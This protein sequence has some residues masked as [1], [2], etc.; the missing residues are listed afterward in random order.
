MPMDVKLTPGTYVVAVSGGIDSMTLLHVLAQQPGLKLV[1]AHYDHGIRSDSKEDRRLVETLSQK[2]GLD[3]E[4]VEGNLDPWV[5]EAEARTKRYEF[6]RQISKKHHAKGIITA[7]HYDDAVETLA[8]NVIRGTKRKGMTAMRSTEEIIRPLLPYTKQDIIDYANTHDLEWREDST[9]LDEKFARNWIRRKLLPKL[10][11][12][13]KK[14]LAHS[15]DDATRRNK[16][17]DELVEA[18]L[19]ELLTQDGIGRQTFIA[20]PH[21]IACEVMAAWLRQNQ[22]TDVNRRLV[23]S[24]VVAAKTLQPGKKVSFGQHRFMVIEQRAIRLG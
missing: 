14:T 1:V 5:S 23:E 22:V 18:Q 3:F 17:V 11:Q 7:H 12:E 4:Y 19:Q 16:I 8:F 6:L 20:L 10:S 21:L 24:L 13:Q 2:Y 15:Y 9:N